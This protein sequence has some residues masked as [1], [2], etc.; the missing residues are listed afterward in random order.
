VISQYDGYT[1]KGLQV[2]GRRTLVE[3]VNDL[4]GLCVAYDAF[5]A[6]GDQSKKEFFNAW[7]TIWRYKY[8]DAVLARVVQKDAHAPAMYRVNGPLAN[9]TAFVEAFGIKEGDG[10][11]KKAEDMVS[12]W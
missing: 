7:A 10:M 3:N 5:M 2:S 9:M 11:Y 1:P 8:Q 6:Q 12:V 4:G